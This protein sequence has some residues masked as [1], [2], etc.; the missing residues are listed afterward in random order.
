VAENFDRGD[1]KNAFFK[2]DNETI[3]GQGIEKSF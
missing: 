2:V 1:F 3:G